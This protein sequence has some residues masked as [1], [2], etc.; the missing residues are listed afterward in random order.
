MAYI[1]S[2]DIVPRII[3]KGCPK[4]WAEV[5]P[6]IAVN[7][8]K[9]KTM[10]VVYLDP[11]TVMKAL[12]LGEGFELE[13]ANEYSF[14]GRIIFIGKQAARVFERDIE[15][16]DLSDILNETPGKLHCTIKKMEAYHAVHLYAE[17]TKRLAS[18]FSLS[19][20]AAAAAP[21]APPLE[22][23]PLVHLA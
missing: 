21:S 23:G 11:K 9:S 18:Q 3:G 22:L 10:G 6:E 19:S 5:I 7:W 20:P 16:N 13:L 8:Q 1:N 12:G 4:W 2:F 14:V 17:I 15:S